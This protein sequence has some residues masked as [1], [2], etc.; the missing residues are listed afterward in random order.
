MKFITLSILT[1]VCLLIFLFLRNNKESIETVAIVTFP[2]QKADIV[3][4]F[5]QDTVIGNFSVARESTKGH[6]H[7]GRKSPLMVI[8]SYSSQA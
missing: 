7:N 5:E 6:A 4:F 3:I 1:I 2:R 8:T